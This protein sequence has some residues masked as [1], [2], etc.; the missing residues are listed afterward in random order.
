MSHVLVNLIVVTVVKF[1][2]LILFFTYMIGGVTYKPTVVKNSD[3]R[4]YVIIGSVDHGMEIPQSSLPDLISSLEDVRALMMEAPKT[5]HEQMHPMS[6]ELLTK[7]S[8]GQV[9]IHY[10]SGNRIDEEIGKHI[11]KYAPKDIAEVYVLCFYVRNCYQLGQEPTLDSIIEFASAYRGR[12]GFLDVKTTVEKYMQVLHHWSGQDLD[13]KD[14]DHFSYDFEK[15]VGDVREFE[16]W[17]P[18]LKEFRRQYPDKV[19]VCVGNYHVPF[20]QAVFDGQEIQAPNWETH[21]DLRRGDRHTPQDADF[22]KR[23]YVNLEAALR[24]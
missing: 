8:V 13:L 11:L 19:A 16:L 22:L 4:P 7:A 12:F 24:G 14:L 1:L 9:P 10:L 2:N 15:F 17:Q 20:V 3:G 21:I 6:T 23:T 18:E 5:T